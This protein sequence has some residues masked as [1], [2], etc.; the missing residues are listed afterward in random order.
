[1]SKPTIAERIIK[2]GAAVFVAHLV[3]KLVGFIQFF[4]VGSIIETSQW[5]TIYGFAFEGVLFSLFLI[6]EE[7]IG[8]AL[9]P[10]FATEKENVSETAAWQI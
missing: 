4:A 10:V 8:P 6:G 1:M 7:L 5:E 3:F 2:A 9:L